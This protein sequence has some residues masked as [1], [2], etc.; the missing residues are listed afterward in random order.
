MIARPPG[1]PTLRLTRAPGG[2]PVAA[3]GDRLDRAVMRGLLLA[4]IEEGRRFAATPAG[5]RWRRVLGEASIGREGLGR[6]GAAGL[7]LFVSGGDRGPDSPRA[8]ADDI[9]ALLAADGPP[10]RAG[11]VMTVA[12]APGEGAGRG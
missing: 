12:P 5:A 10:G 9:L 8:M 4:L 11:L 1:P 3:A 6:W 2:D 7:D